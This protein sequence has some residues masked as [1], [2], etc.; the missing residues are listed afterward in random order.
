MN[1]NNILVICVDDSGNKEVTI[2]KIYEADISQY[3]YV[4]EMKLDW[5][6][7]EWIF[8]NNLDHR[9]SG[10][11]Y[12]KRFIELP[13]LKESNDNVNLMI[14]ADNDETARYLTVGKIY[15][16]DVSNLKM[17]YFKEKY[18]KMGWIL[19]TDDN[20]PGYTPLCQFIE[21]PKIK[22]K[23]ENNMCSTNGSKIL[24]M[25]VDNKGNLTRDLTVGKIYQGNRNE[26][27]DITTDQIYIYKFNDGSTG[28][29]YKNRFIELPIPKDKD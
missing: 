2:G 27:F 17:H 9:S 21:L 28:R 18:E 7:R 22:E 3:Y 20:I 5:K 23:M 19:D 26:W 13:K 10:W 14:C 16:I 29:C 1:K 15:K 12:T 25:C 8:I 4:S 6:E 24:L 11:V